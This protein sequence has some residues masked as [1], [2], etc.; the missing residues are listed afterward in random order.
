MGSGERGVPQSAQGAYGCVNSVALTP[1]GRKG[2]SGSRDKT[3]RVW[4]L[5]SGECLKVL[6][7]HTNSVRSVALTPDGRK[8][9]SGGE[10]KTVRVWDLESRVC[11]KVLEGHTECCV[12]CCADAGWTQGDL[13]E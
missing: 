4:D 6:K 3:V 10:D 9:I 1:D 11:L 7:G 5:E 8:G 12:E 13:G 2:I